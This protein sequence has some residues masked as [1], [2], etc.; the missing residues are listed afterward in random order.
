MTETAGTATLA[1]TLSYDGAPFAGFARQP[2]QLTVQGVL[3]DALRVVM[4]REVETTGAGRTDAGVH[5]LGQVVSLDL[6]P[7]EDPDLHA[8]VRSL[9]GLAGPHI[10]VTEA[11]MAPPGFSARFDAVAREYHYR[12]VPGPVPPVF[13]APHAWWVKRSLDLGAMRRAAGPLVGEHDFRSFCVADSAQGKRTVR[14]IELLDITTE[15]ELGE[16][17]IQIRVVGNAFLHS[18][19]RVIA[20]TLVEVGT[21]RQSESWVEQ[22]LDARDRGAA[23]PT[24]PPQ[25]LTLWHVSY[26]EEVWL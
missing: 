18:M 19:V 4:R 5:A 21:G 17:A 15:R 13:L 20:G 11:R 6:L 25:G 16:H 22:A 2:E 3:E 12:I 24:A 8:L 9:N 23:G 10:V 14:T 26:P 1:L 7:A